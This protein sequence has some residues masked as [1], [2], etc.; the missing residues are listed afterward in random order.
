MGPIY[1]Q[2]I[3]QKYCLLLFF[4]PDC[5]FARPRCFQKCPDTFLVLPVTHYFGS[6]LGLSALAARQRSNQDVCITEPKVC[7]MGQHKNMCLGIIHP[8]MYFEKRMYR[9]KGQIMKKKEGST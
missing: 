5:P 1:L 4:F 7:K 2:T 3:I 6:T 8:F 9:A